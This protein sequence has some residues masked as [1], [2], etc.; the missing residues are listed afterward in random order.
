MT[1]ALVASAAALLGYAAGRLRP[2]HHLIGWAKNLRPPRANHRR[3]HTRYEPDWAAPPAI[4][5]TPQ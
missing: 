5:R 1:A 4:E 3:A 2:A